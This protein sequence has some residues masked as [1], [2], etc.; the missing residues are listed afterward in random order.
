MGDV[1]NIMFTSE[2][3]TFSDFCVMTCDWPLMLLAYL[4]LGDSY[5]LHF[6]LE[7][8]KKREIYNLFNVSE[9]GSAG[10]RFYRLTG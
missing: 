2:K 9:L 8:T 3:V 7:E 6:T 4:T 1:E 5:N 10:S